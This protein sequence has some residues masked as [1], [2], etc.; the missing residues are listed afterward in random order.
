MKLSVVHSLVAIFFVSLLV[1]PILGQQ[2]N[3]QVISSQG[4]INGGGKLGWL[5]VD[6]RWIKDESNNTISF[7]GTTLAT[8][9]WIWDT[10]EYWNHAQDPIPMANRMADLGVTWVRITI[11]RQFWIDQEIGASYKDLIDRYV[12]E[13][14]LRN[15]YCTVGLMSHDILGDDQ[16]IWLDFLAELATRYIDNPGMCGIY[17]YNEPQTPPYYADVWHEWANLGAQTIHNIN[18]SLLILLHGNLWQDPSRI[19]PYWVTNPIPV[20]NVV[21]LYHHYFWQEW[22]YAHRDFAESYEAGNY[23]LAKQQMEAALYDR[24]WKYAVEHNLCIMNEELGFNDPVD[25]S[26]TDMGYSPG[27]PQCMHDYLE[28]HNKYSIPWNEYAWF[29]GGYGLSDA[30]NLNNVGEI[31]VQYLNPPVP[32]G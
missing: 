24:Y 25:A 20:P 1:F 18:P 4:G 27:F 23:A 32:T 11:S 16:A 14:T 10:H 7:T 30:V 12:R 31:W 6:G 9:A 13:F 17:I 15:V 2:Q 22:W 28:L 26:P 19:D 3:V 8:T 29:Q 5:H 21:Y